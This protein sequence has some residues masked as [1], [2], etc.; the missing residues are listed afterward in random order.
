MQDA[1][2]GVRLAILDCDHLANE[3]K[4]QYHSYGWMFS[5]LFQRQLPQL[6]TQRFS[7]IDGDYPGSDQQFDGWLITGSKADA[8]ASVDWIDGLK[9]YLQQLN[10]QK[11]CLI[12]ICFGHQLLAHMFGGQ[13]ARAPQ[14]WGVGVMDYTTT[15]AVAEFGLSPGK[16]LRLIASHQDQVLALP[17]GAVRL[18]CDSFCPNAAFMLDSH[19]IGIQGHPE[20]SKAYAA[21][22]YRS[23]T[24]G[25]GERLEPA[26]QSLTKPTDEAA[27][28]QLIYQHIVSC[29]G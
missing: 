29:R 28:S 20:F 6:Q 5:Q 3:V 10:Q 27:V 23:R 8:F 22:I 17:K 12:G 25:I 11:Q 24:E 19:I 7:V 26:L 13:V 15:Q 2:R 21:W 14:G 16:P 9:D 18:W 1:D 4:A